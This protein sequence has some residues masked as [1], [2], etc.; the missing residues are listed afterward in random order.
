M[1]EK[2]IFF[3]LDSAQSEG[4]RMKTEKK[5]ETENEKS[6]VCDRLLQRTRKTTG[7]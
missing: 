1:P 7:P 2:G 4:C 5:E 3:C 6:V